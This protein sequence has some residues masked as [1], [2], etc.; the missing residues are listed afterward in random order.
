MFAA[1]EAKTIKLPKEKPSGILWVEAA[2]F[3]FL[4]G[5]SWLTEAIRIP[6]FLFGEAFVPNWRRAALRTII[7]LLIWFWVYMVT[8]R[9]LKRLHHLEEFLRVC[10]WCRKVCHDGE[11]VAMENFL[12]SKFDTKTTHGMCPD[13]LK[14]KVKE[15]G[16]KE[17]LTLV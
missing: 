6:H 9:L 7:M 15:I 1:D 10:G 17:K 14:K 12:N 2:G 16:A 5:L 3:S 8:R 11:W 4:I 13:C